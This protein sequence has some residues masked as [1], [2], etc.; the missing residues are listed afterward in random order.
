MEPPLGIEPRT[1]RLNMVARLPAE[2]RRER[3]RAAAASRLLPRRPSGRIVS[4]PEW[5]LTLVH[6]AVEQAMNTIGAAHAGLPA[7]DWMLRF[8][9]TLLGSAR[10]DVRGYDEQLAAVTRW[11][12]TLEMTAEPAFEVPPFTYYTWHGQI[13]EREIEITIYVKKV[14]E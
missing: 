1:F 6:E 9:G 13:N 12:Q 5:D 11:I 8:D 7:L 10:Y 3:A 4:A 2:T 14:T